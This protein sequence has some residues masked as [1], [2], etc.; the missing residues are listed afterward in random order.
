MAHAPSRA[1]LVPSAL[2]LGGLLTRIDRGPAELG[3]PGLGGHRSPAATR[4]RNQFERPNHL[5]LAVQP[6]AVRLRYTAQRQLTYRS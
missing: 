5:R 6:K 3:S 1:R 4:C 2:V